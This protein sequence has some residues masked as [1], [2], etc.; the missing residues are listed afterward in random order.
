MFVLVAVST[1]LVMVIFPVNVPA[2]TAALIVVALMILNAAAT[3][4]N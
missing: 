1:A 2:G 4:L 3:P